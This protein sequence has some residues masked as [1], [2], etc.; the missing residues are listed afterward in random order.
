MGNRS[1]M[2]SSGHLLRLLYRSRCRMSSG[3]RGEN[4]AMSLWSEGYWGSGSDK[5][6]CSC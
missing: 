3:E 5:T 1:G 2:G 6:V 4:H